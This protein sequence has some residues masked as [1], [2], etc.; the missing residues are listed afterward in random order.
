MKDLRH[1]KLEHTI[2][3]RHRAMV[4]VSS[5]SLT[6][7]PPVVAMSPMMTTTTT[8][9]CPRNGAE[10]S[11][12]TYRRTECCSR[13][14]RFERG[15]TVRRRFRRTQGTSVARPLTAFVV[16]VVFSKT[17]PLLSV[18]FRDPRR[19]GRSVGSSQSRQANTQ[20]PASRHRCDHLRYHLRQWP[21][22]PRLKRPSLTRLLQRRGEARRRSG[23]SRRRS[24]VEAAVTKTART[25]A[26][27]ISVWRNC[28][29]SGE[30]ASPNI[31]T[32][33]DTN[34][35]GLCVYISLVAV[36]PP[37]LI[38]SIS[39]RRL[40]LAIP[41]PLTTILNVSVYP[42]ALYTLSTMM[43]YPANHI[44]RDGML[45]VRPRRHATL[46]RDRTLQAA[47]LSDRTLHTGTLP[48]VDYL[49]PFARPLH[50]PTT[51]SLDNGP[52]SN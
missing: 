18:E 8:S 30:V 42:L 40:L 29:R 21:L 39:F 20:P 28:C 2:W 25:Q 43:S 50:L 44:C 49:T 35:N 7:G 32:S 16:F 17:V 23:W 46:H 52:H 26:A 27:S 14:C 12:G 51:D 1:G 33:D 6:A 47:L 41:M 15:F 4:Y 37:R 45:A 38:S 19:S 34:Q 48:T 5:L 24:R 31:A 13:G 9:P 11:C 36:P 3:E 10:T 22:C